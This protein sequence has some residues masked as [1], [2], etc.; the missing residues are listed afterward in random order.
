MPDFEEIASIND[1]GD[2]DRL[3]VFLGDT[4]ALL[5]RIQDQFLA[6]E[7]VCTH[8]GQP[9]TNGCI[10][11]GAIICPRHGAR[12]DL[13]TGKALCMPATKPIQ[14][15]EVEVRGQKIFVRH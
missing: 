15:F 12:F 5:I 14:T 4:P 9:L 1:F 10:E 11:E 7:D 2:A 3:E 8:D 13:V 6:I